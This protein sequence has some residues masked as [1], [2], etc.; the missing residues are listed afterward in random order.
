MAQKK[1]LYLEIETS[2]LRNTF[3]W[4]EWSGAV[5]DLGTLLPLGF[6]LVVFNGFPPERLFFLWGVV[7]ILSGWY[8]KVPVSV[9]PLKAMAV[10]AISMGFSTELLAST[11]FFYGLLMILLA[12]TGIIRWLQ[13][14]FSPALVRGVQ[15][16]IGLILAQKAV[17]LV[18]EK[19]LL[20]QLP[21]AHLFLSVGLLVAVLMVL[22]VFQFRKKI[23]VV[24]ILIVISV[25]V[26]A[27]SGVRPHPDHP[28]HSPVQLT[29]PE[30][31]FLWMA[32]IYLMLPQ[33]PLTLGN[34]VFAASDAC[35]AFWKQRS[36]RVNPTRLAL[37]IGISDA[38][39]GLL[40]GFPICHGAGGI[41]AHAQFGGKTG[42]TTIIMGGLLVLVALIPSTASLLFLIPVPILSAMLIFDSWRMMTLIQ[43]LSHRR[44]MGVALVVG[45]VSFL[46]RNLSIALL[47]GFVLERAWNYYA[48]RVSIVSQESHHD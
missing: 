14:W 48:K 35:H 36:R 42:G 9:Q 30:L 23:P 8:Y 12:L 3:G 26:V 1:P 21:R 13:K 6:A 46:T 16:G 47:I 18:L 27:L 40:G 24:L 19:G 37:S 7:Y 41:G 25:A 32:L 15:L 2:R 31:S 17:Q 33:L 11:S 10:I 4:S 20:L 29:L 39:I 43:K 34:A 38:A 44:E 45:L 5:G 28:G 22:W